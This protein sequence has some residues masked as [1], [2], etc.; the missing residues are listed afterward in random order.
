MVL[1]CTDRLSCQ[2]SRHQWPSTTFT[3]APEPREAKRIGFML[4]LVVPEDFDELD[5]EVT[6][7]FEGKV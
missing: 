1:P 4:D 2:G 3:I 6:N 7:L 5:N